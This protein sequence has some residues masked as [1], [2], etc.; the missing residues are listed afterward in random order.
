MSALSEELKSVS[1]LLTY[2]TKADAD[3]DKIIAALEKDG[4]A[5]EAKRERAK[6]W[7]YRG[8]SKLASDP[9]YRL[10][11]SVARAPNIQK[12]PYEEL[13][14]LEIRSHDIFRKQTV[15]NTTPV[16][17]GAWEVLALAQH[18]SLPTR[19]MDWTSNP[20]VALYFAVRNPEHDKKSDG[21]DNQSAVYVLTQQTLTF[22]ELMERT[23]S[24][25]RSAME[26]SIET[27]KGKRNQIEER[28]M[29][30]LLRTEEVTP[31]EI[32]ENI[33]YDPPHVSPR[34]RAQDGLLLAFSN[35][36]QELPDSSYIELRIP[37][38]HRDKIRR[39]L[40]SYG[41]FDKQLFPELDGLARWLK[42][43]VFDSFEETR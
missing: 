32:K 40:E 33:I 9:D 16:P 18:H 5:D 17:R 38:K 35:P 2:L 37:G 7:I 8:Q 28:H 10:I 14:K 27:K 24:E 20:L 26:S 41:V 11:P 34:I 13:V 31:F 25:S 21:S 19:F 12:L 1:D 6:K 4:K 23:R 22:E 42:F 36:L 15:A 39:E 29:K 3:K 30:V 43:K